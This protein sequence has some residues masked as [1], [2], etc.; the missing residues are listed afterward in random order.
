MC[1]WWCWL[2][3]PVVLDD[4]GDEV[5][6]GQVVADGH[7]HA[8]G[9]SGGIVLQQILH[10]SLGV[11][12]EGGVEVGLVLFG[13]GSATDRVGIVV[14][15]DATSGIKSMVNPFSIADV[16]N[17]EGAHHIGAD[18]L[19]LV[20]LTPIHI[21]TAGHASGIEHM[22]GLDCLNLS[23]NA[24][25]VMGARIGQMEGLALSGQELDQLAT[26]PA[27]LAENEINLIIT[28]SKRS[29]SLKSELR[30]ERMMS[31]PRDGL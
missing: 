20:V 11:G 8:Q 27:I 2:A 26:D 25:T 10:K 1:G 17:G 30:E 4:L 22:C 3:Y 28:A 14:L 6:G 7:P 31:K 5:A 29:H 12:V 15:K 16:S 19:L 9:Q 13:E 21:G 18:G 24:L 23:Q